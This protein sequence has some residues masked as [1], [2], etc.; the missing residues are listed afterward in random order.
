[1][2]MLYVFGIIIAMT[3][4]QLAASHRSYWKGRMEGWQA[5]EGMVLDRAKEHA[6]YDERNV[7][8]DLVQ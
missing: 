3:V 6:S 1:M 8:K 2:N 7:W 5:C 4:I